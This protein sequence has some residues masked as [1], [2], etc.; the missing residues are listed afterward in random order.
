MKG[1][2]MDLILWRHAEARDLPDGAVAQPTARYRLGLC[3]AESARRFLCFTIEH[4]LRIFAPF[5]VSTKAGEFHLGAPQ[6]MK[7][8]TARRGFLDFT[9]SVALTEIRSRCSHGPILA[10]AGMPTAAGY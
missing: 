9:F 5:G 2:V 4:S 3:S 1:P 10:A 6:F 8:F 7:S